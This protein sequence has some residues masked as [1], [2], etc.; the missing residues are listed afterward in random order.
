[1]APGAPQ[2]ET[3]LPVVPLREMVVLPHMIAGL[4]M[5]RPRSVAAVETALIEGRSLLLVAQRDSKLEAPTAADLHEMGTVGEILQSFRQPDGTFRVLFEAK[6]RARILRVDDGDGPLRAAYEAL[7]APEEK[8]ETID[9]W[10]RHVREQ[11]AEIMPLDKRLPP[12]ASLA[13]D[14]IHGASHLADMAG[15]YLVHDLSCRQAMLETV[16]VQERLEIL[17][18]HLATL[19][20]QLKLDQEI[21]EKVKS[22]LDKAQREYFLREKLQQ[23]HRELGEEDEKTKEISDYRKAIA[24]AKLPKE[25]R[26]RAER[27]LGRLQRTGPQSAESGVI[28]SYLDTLAALPWDKRT[29]DQLDLGH[30]Q[31][32]LDAGHHGLEKVKDRLLEFLAV[33]ALRKSPPTTIL[34]LVGPPGVGKTSLARAIADALGRKFVRAS[35]GGV[36]DEAEI[37]GHR[38]TYVGAMPGRILAGLKTAGTKN[39]VFLLD[40]LDKLGSDSRSNPSAALLEVL[41]PEQNR[42][43]SDHYVESPFD[44]SEVLFI[45]TA[46]GTAGIPAALR[47]RLEIIRIGSYTE[48]EK[49]SIAEKHLLPKTLETHGLKSAQL[50]VDRDTLEALVRGYTREAGVRQLSRRLA[51]LARKAARAV[52]AGNASLAVSPEALSALLGPAPHRH[53]EPHRSPEVGTV[54]GLAWTEAG[55]S[56]LT[57]EVAKLKGKGRLSLTGHLGDVMKESAQAAFTFVK[58]NAEAL[59][60]AEE[61]WLQHDLHLHVPQGAI[62][63]DGPSAGMAMA[64]A[65]ASVLSGRPVRS[66]LAM[67]GEISL[68]GRVMA[69]GGV[70][71]KVLAAHRAE[72]DLVILP[73]ENQADLEDV[74]AEV[75]E[76]MAFRFVSRAEET[77]ALALLPTLKGRVPQAL[78]SLG[79]ADA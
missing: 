53:R 39:P 16:G 59:G 60:I 9:A 11:L 68:R 43:F 52:V 17:A 61:A 73:E 21:H 79:A 29:K 8:G 18:N 19:L 6:T 27:E 56:M 46:N 24:K 75:R 58:A 51:S 1:M 78:A 44:L 72:L 13:I 55:G 49:L 66:D 10:E 71:E 41:D 54:N 37:R 50:E 3:T 28:R 31:D 33:R 63:K 62:P 32:V 2:A 57:I 35:L 67:T 5:G 26:E 30:A 25:A 65:I 45:A 47:D 20:E 40:E 14:T 12:E 23:I 4:S 64:V 42:T 34:C 36:H 77:L 22:K 76:A 69:I 48:R 15:S 38:R 7:S 74:P 70:K